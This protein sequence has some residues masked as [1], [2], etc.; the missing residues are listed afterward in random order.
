MRNSNKAMLV[1]IDME[2]VGTSIGNITLE[3]TARMVTSNMK[4]DTST[5]RIVQEAIAKVTKIKTSMHLY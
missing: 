1:T 3:A 5:G 2:E 4:V